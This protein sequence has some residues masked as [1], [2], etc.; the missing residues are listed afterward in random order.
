MLALFAWVTG[1]VASQVLPG[2]APLNALI[3]TTVMHVALQK[4]AL[5]RNPAVQVSA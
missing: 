3:V 1:I 5:S 4:F 2:I